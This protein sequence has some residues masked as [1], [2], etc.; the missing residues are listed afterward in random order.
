MQLFV[1]NLV[2]KSLWNYL[3][4]SGEFRFLYHYPC[5][6]LTISCFC[7][8]EN[9]VKAEDPLPRKIY[10]LHKIC[11]NFRGVFKSLS[12]QV[13]NSALNLRFSPRA[14][15]S[16]SR[17]RIGQ[18]PGLGRQGLGFSSKSSPRVWDASVIS[19]QSFLSCCCN[20]SKT[21][22]DI[23]DL[24]GVGRLKYLFHNQEGLVN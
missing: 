14:Q 12:L 10:A 19:C 18:L 23:A 24:T 5:W 3:L 11:F 21:S 22:R 8:F 9:L 17:A 15:V 4:N 20:H 1:A 6:F 2:F 16:G 7:V 13:K